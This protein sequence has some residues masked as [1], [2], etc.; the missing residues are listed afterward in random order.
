MKMKTTYDDQSEHADYDADEHE[1]Y[2]DADEDSG[3]QNTHDID[4]GVVFEIR[5]KMRLIM[6]YRIL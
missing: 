1:E 5:I 4:D 6:N 3:L 2:D